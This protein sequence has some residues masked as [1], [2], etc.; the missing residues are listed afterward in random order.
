[1]ISLLKECRSPALGEVFTGGRYYKPVKNLISGRNLWLIV[2]V[3]NS[4]HNSDLQMDDPSN[5]S[6][7]KP[8][9]TWQN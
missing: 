8:K 2:V 1:M 6:G 5:P 9:P 7:K 3:L 4:I